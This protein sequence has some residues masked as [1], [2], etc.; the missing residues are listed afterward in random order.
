MFDKKIFRSLRG[1]QSV[2]MDRGF[3]DCK[4]YMSLLKEKGGNHLS[5][6]AFL[7]DKEIFW[8]EQNSVCILYRR[9]ANKLIVLGDPI[10]DETLFQQSIKEFCAYGNSKGL[11][12]VFYQISPQYMHH[13]HNSGYR[14]IKL[15]EEGKVG[16]EQFSLEGKQG[17]KMR[18]ILNKFTRSGCEFSVIQPPYCK[19][20][21]SEMKQ[22][23]N[24]W[25]G[26]QHEKRFSVASF[27][28]EYVSRFP[29]AVLKDSEGN[30][31]AFSTLATDYQNTVSVDLM[32]KSSES[33]NGTME[34]LFIEIFKW[35]KTN[36]YHTCSLGM[37]PLSNVG[38]CKHAFISE[39]LIHLA[40]NHGNSLYNFKGLRDFK[41]KFASHW[42][43]K[44][45]AYKGPLLP[46][47]FIQ[48][49]LLINKQPLRAAQPVKNNYFL[50]V[51]RTAVKLR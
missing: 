16:L 13:Y 43:P 15:G 50:D 38:N 34:M 42:E 33:P 28:E 30:I 44:Y 41:S 1:K 40:Y 46:I 19:D 8:T 17:A 26:N 35:A 25:L 7:N 6:L 22:V 24:S 11:K 29:V 23:S 37:S 9:F 32:R 21:L 2:K 18:T 31:L 4:Q 49:I 10:G 48:L 3:N 45:L 20:L 27:T 39:K 51:L 36:G 12:T 47:I 5:H 14:F